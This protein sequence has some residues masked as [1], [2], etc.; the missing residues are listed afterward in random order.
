MPAM[1]A[2][3]GQGEFAGFCKRLGHGKK[4]IVAI[5][6]V[7]RKIVITLGS[8]MLSQDLPH[9]E[10]RAERASKG[11][12]ID[13]QEYVTH[14]EE[15]A[16]HVSGGYALVKVIAWLLRNRIEETIMTIQF[17]A[18]PT[19]EVR[20]LQRGGPDAYGFAPERKTSDGDGV[21]CRH[22][23]GN[24][25]AGN[26]YLIVAYRPFPALQPYAETG[27]IFLHADE[28]QRAPEDEALP[29]LFTRTKDYIVRGDG[30]DDRIVY[31][32][33]PWC[34]PLKYRR[35]PRRC[36]RAPTSPIC[37]CARRATIATSA[38]SSE[39]PISSR[40]SG[41]TRRTSTTCP[42]RCRQGRPAG[43]SGR[44]PGKQRRD[45]DIGGNADRRDD[46]GV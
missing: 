20:R 35:A 2:A 24:V 38:A 12:A 45:R 9:P 7:M 10:V 42:A 46:Q 19:E 36:W 23:L 1:R 21:P 40:R 30:P 13:P 27:P 26:D 29:E 34:R 3:A 22:C 18:L 4:P 43:R 41:W 28:C 8:G 16:Q 6:A 32:P 44:P 37:T 17:K 5:A 39:G 33:A 15:C 31:G 25:A 11:A 14:C